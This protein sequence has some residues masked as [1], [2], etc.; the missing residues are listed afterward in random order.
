QE[1]ASR[2]VAELAAEILALKER[3]NTLDEELG[4]RFFDRPEARILT[5]LP[6][7]Q[8]KAAKALVLHHYGCAG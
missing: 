7:M 6:G 1:V 2:I 4:Q 5:S 8:E 3:I